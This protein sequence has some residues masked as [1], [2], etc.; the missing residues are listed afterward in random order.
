MT[1]SSDG[2]FN[3]IEI[4]QGPCDPKELKAM[5]LGRIDRDPTEA[6]EEDFTRDLASL[7]PRDQEHVLAAVKAK[8]GPAGRARQALGRE[9]K[10]Q[11]EQ[12]RS[13]SNSEAPS[14]AGSVAE[15]TACAGPY[16]MRPEGIWKRSTTDEGRPTSRKLCNFSAKITSCVRVIDLD[17]ERSE[18]ELA[19]TVNGASRVVRVP[20]EEF[21]PMRW[22]SGIGPNAIME[23][24]AELLL[25]HAIQTVS[26]PVPERKVYA[27]TGWHKIEESW[28][29]LHGGGAIGAA[30][31]LPGINCELT[32]EVRRFVLPRPLEGDALKAA[33][34]VVLDHL[35]LRPA[36]TVPVVSAAFRAAI[37]GEC[38]GSLYLG[39]EQESGKTF[40]ASGGQQYFGASMDDRHPP[41]SVRSTSSL[42]VV[43]AMAQAGDALFLYDDLKIRGIVGDDARLVDRV[44]HVVRARFSNTG[45]NVA[46]RDGSVISEP[47]PRCYPIITG[48]VLPP[49]HSL[50]S[51]MLIIEV[52]DRQVTSESTRLAEHAR[53]GTLA[54][55]MAS[56]LRW[57][58]PQLDDVRA[59]VARDAAEEARQLR[60]RTKL[61]R[62]VDLAADL[63][64][65]LRCFLRFAREDGALE[66]PAAADL[67]DRCREELEALTAAQARHQAEQDPAL[68]FLELLVDALAAGD[69]HL[70][71]PKDNGEPPSSHLLGWHQRSGERDHESPVRV[72]GGS[73]VGYCDGT[74]VWLIPNAALQAARAAADR[75]DPL[76]VTSVRELGKLLHRRKL[77]R[78]TDIDTARATYP[79]R[80]TVAGATK[81]QGLHL[82]LEKLHTS[83]A[84]SSA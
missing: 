11:A 67:L 44:E 52:P 16:L 31:A 50:R 25:P 49:G 35:M 8:G 77:L 83:S 4:E 3:D 27:F 66:A 47:P 59:T 82:A 51:R 58:A 22:V 43:R 84:P 30:G 46:G 78:S 38:N 69:C 2:A 54:A 65:G 55:A 9:L 21:R 7:P 56:F 63:L 37:G 10:R 64:A 12:P 61:Q 23:P 14:A 60:A 26:A 76:P 41:A 15:G 20:A 81:F 29:Y 57:L 48:E 5:L 19:V 53:Q 32:A 74:D 72:A 62:A 75:G 39:A 45:R 40:W 36:V 1:I 33:V 18:W 71:H 70:R 34:Q 13:A 6:V 79:V 42:H 24:G 73:C 80:K 68:R 17:R 28:V